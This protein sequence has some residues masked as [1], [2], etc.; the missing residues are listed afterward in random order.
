MDLKTEARNRQANLGEPLPL[1]SFDAPR[2]GGATEPLNALAQKMGT[3]VALI[4]GACAL[5]DIPPYIHL[6]RQCWEEMRHHIP[7]RGRVRCRPLYYQPPCWR[8][9]S[10]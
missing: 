10:T 4:Q 2:S 7:P 5:D 8:C 3:E 6:D 1:E 9:G